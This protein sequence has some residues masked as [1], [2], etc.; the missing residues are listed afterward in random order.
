MKRSLRFRAGAALVI[1][2]GLVAC[3]LDPLNPQP[4]PP[5]P[6]PAFAGYAD[7]AAP[8]PDATRT[9]DS[10]SNDAGATGSPDGGG[11]PPQNTPDAGDTDAS[12]AGDAGDADTGAPS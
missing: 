8:R 7:G 10:L 9:E 1:A 12:D 4:L 11:P 5:G 2:G 3:A 6:D